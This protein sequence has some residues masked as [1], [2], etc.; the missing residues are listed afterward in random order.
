MVFSGFFCLLRLT[1]RGYLV[2]DRVAILTLP[3]RGHGASGSHVR[4]PYH[5]GELGCRGRHLHLSMTVRYLFSLKSTRSG[6][7]QNKR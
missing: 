7:L 5:D 2:F 6:A 3:Q 1:G 4:L